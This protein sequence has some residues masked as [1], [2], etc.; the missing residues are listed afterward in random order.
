[1]TVVSMLAK[2]YQWKKICFF[3]MFCGINNA[4]CLP[5]SFYFPSEH[6]GS[7]HFPI[8]ITVNFGPHD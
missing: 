2:I 5:N 3:L 6:T 7:P 4:I 8:F 1:M